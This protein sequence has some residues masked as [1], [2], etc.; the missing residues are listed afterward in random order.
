M[1]HFLKCVCASLLLLTFPIAILDAQEAD[2]WSRFRGPNGSGVAEGIE[3]PER[4]MSHVAWRQPLP[5]GHSSPIVSK[6]RLY[7]QSADSEAGRQTLHCF[8]AATGETL[9]ER[10]TEFE[11]YRI[12]ERNS[13]GSATP[14]ADDSGVYLVWGSVAENRIVKFN[15]DG[16]KQWEREVGGFQCNHGSAVALVIV[17]GMVICPLM[18]EAPKGGK[19]DRKIDPRILALDDES[20][21]L[22]WT[23]QRPQGKAS[24][25]TPCVIGEG[26]D[27][28]L[29]FCNT[30]DGMFSLSPKDGSENW[31]LPVFE[32]RTVSSTV[33]AGDLLIGSNG[34][35]GGGNYLVAVRPGKKPEEV[36]RVR[37]APY[38]PTPLFK[39]GMLFLWNDKGIASCVDAAT[40]EL[41][42]RERVGGS[43]SASPVCIGNR[44]VCIDDSGEAFVIVAS[45]EYQLHGK[46]SLGAT[47]RSTPA[48]HS[49]RQENTEHVYFRTESELIAIKAEPTDDK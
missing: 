4:P 32:R 10:S 45:K 9:W 24:F 34:S 48:V 47:T 41:H 7:V 31:A 15:H 49:D 44:L 3:L 23:A 33:L 13:H 26:D 36:Y 6:N 30:A 8:D 18:E 38:V 25:S 35:G 11:P 12:H 2:D 27:K 1:G 28:E 21:E 16:T 40:G 17:D 46:F 29:I 14:A 39:D 37:Q 19:S 20:G 43:S 22:R 5:I 42:W